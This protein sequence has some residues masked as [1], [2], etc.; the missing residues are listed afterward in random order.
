MTT[1]N[2]LTALELL[3]RAQGGDSDAYSEIY[4]RQRPKIYGYIHKRVPYRSICEELTQEVFARMLR[5][6]QLHEYRGTADPISFALTIA[7]N[8]VYDYYKAMPRKQAAGVPAEWWEPDG[9]LDR[10]DPCD[11]P[12]ERANQIATRAALVAAMRQLRPDQ[13]RAVALRYLYDL[14]FATVA[15]EMGLSVGAVKALCFRAVRKL[16]VIL[17]ETMEIAA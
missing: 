10:P 16:A 5:H 9:L 3:L 11:G 12:A 7:R 15:T 1:T 4:V 17:A 13:Q 2:Q 8:L 6:F 14:P